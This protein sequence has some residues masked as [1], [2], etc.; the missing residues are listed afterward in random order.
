MVDGKTV[1]SKLARR[2]QRVGTH[3]AIRLD[4]LAT[5]EVDGEPELGTIQPMPP[6]LLSA[7]IGTALVEMTSRILLGHT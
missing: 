6:S 1:A 2:T 5:L 7:P 3:Q 4:G